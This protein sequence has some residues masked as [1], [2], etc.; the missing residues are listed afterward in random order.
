MVDGGKYQKALEELEKSRPAFIVEPQVCL[1]LGLRL[2]SFY[3]FPS[4]FLCCCC[5]FAFTTSWLPR[6]LAD[7]AFFSFLCKF[8]FLLSNLTIICSFSFFF[9]AS[10]S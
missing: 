8:V 9:L 2:Y 6:L 3:S 4:L 10:C 7:L 5:A 1:L